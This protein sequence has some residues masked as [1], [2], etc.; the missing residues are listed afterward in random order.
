VSKQRVIA[1]AGKKHSG[2][3]TFFELLQKQNPGFVR[4]SLA[5]FLR[6]DA[7]LLPG[8][9]TLEANPVYPQDIKKEMLR[10]LWKAAAD[11]MKAAYGEQFF[12][13][14][15]VSDINANPRPVYVV[16]DCRL[17]SEA[18]AFREHFD[19]KVVHIVRPSSE[20]KE[21]DTH[22]T[23]TEPAL[24]KAD[25]SIYNNRDGLGYLEATAKEIAEEYFP[26][27]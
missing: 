26:N 21:V 12:I 15:T 5:D 24:I 13:Q 8:V 25:Y 23:E 16:T 17:R 10:P 19:C 7:R 9:K 4:I 22:K 6:E 11:V 20:P 14:R 27:E 3:D 1:I 2:K 18:K